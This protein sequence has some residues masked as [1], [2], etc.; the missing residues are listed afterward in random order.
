MKITFKNM[1]S[2]TI[3]VPLKSTK[4]ILVKY[5]KKSLKGYKTSWVSSKPNVA[6]ISSKGT[7]IPLKKGSTK[8]THILFN[9]KS[10]KKIKKTLRVKVVSE[11]RIKKITCQESQKDRTILKY[12]K[13][14]YWKLSLSPSKASLGSL[15][16]KSSNKKIAKIS[17]NGVITP[18]KNGYVTISAI[19]PKT[20]VRISRKFR[21][22][23]PI[24]KIKTSNKS[25]SIPCYSSRQLSVRITPP[26]AT[27]KSIYWSSDN[28]T[29][30]TVTQ[31]GYVTTHGVGSA[32]IT[33]SSTDGS[34][35]KM[36]FAIKS[37]A[38][39]GLVTS[40]LLDKYDLKDG[41]NLMIVAHPD[42]DM[43]WGGGNMIQAINNGEQYFV[44]CLTNGSHPSRPRDF[45]LAMNDIGAKHMILSYPD[46]YL[47]RQVNWLPYISYIKK[48]VETLL[49][50][51]NWGRIVT[52][53]PDG[54]YGHQHH[55]KTS[56]IVSEIS[57]INIPNFEKLYYFAK[58][59]PE[60]SI[61][62][63]VKEKQ[64]PTD[65]L[66]QKKEIIFNRYGDRSA[67]Y[68]FGFYIPYETWC[69]ASSWN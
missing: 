51:R 55:K 36:T 18:L 46:V 66:D 69:K 52:H 32:K 54:E 60:T 7:I 33:A 34:N 64:L 49:H 13:K 68:M 17:K 65:I 16:F 39:N 37:T 14:Y 53:N 30:A 41:D 58:Y 21:I 19:C 62:E 25:I 40:S 6:K 1:S 4:K 11:I 44:V 5:S 61:P 45:N 27:N 38:T 28:E 15:T 20:K 50:Y 3:Q 22:I 43:L 67:V 23:T 26:T 35:K 47:S 8:I 59:Y 31:S 29:V 48:D 24:Q 12:P 63:A 56:E 9:K 42:D 10:K 57:K 2:K